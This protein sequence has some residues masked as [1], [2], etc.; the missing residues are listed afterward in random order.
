MTDMQNERKSGKRKTGRAHPA[1]GSEPEHS[2]YVYGSAGIAEREG[3]VPVWLWC[4]VVSLLI[5]GIYYL[6]TYWN[7]PVAP[8]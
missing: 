4:V 1:S 8:S 5:W 6:V 2:V 3:R 7:A